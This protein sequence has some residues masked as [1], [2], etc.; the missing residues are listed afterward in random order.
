MYQ[1]QY[2]T[3]LQDLR[4]HAYYLELY[5]QRSERIE[6]G[7]GIFLAVASSASI[8]AWTIWTKASM[9]WGGII[10]AS[11]VV[12]V[13]YKFLPF[14]ARIKPLNSASIELFSLADEAE[15]GWHDVAEGELTGSKVNEMRFKIRSKKSAIM[16]ASFTGISLPEDKELMREAEAK[17]RAYFSNFYTGADDE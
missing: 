10:A 6:T 11:Q 13:V 15:K 12:G 7:I 3:E 5:Q 2:W 8:G 14:K 1:S 17:M 16:K 4:A 9:V